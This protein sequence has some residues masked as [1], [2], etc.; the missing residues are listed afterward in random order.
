M[1]AGNRIAKGENY[2]KICLWNAL[3]GS[4]LIFFQLTQRHRKMKKSEVDTIFGN[5]EKPTLTENFFTGQT[6]LRRLSSK[7]TMFL[8]RR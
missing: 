7:K 8:M 6:Y 1:Y 5:K 4:I 3:L 2:A